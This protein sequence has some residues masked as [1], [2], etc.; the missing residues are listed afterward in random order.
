MVTLQQLARQSSLP[1]E[2]LIA[3]DGSGPETSKAVEAF[4][5]I[6]HNLNVFHIWHEDIGFDKCGV[7]NLAI[8][9]ARSDY[10]L[11]LDDD[12]PC[13]SHFIAEH[14]KR[15]LFGS[16]TVGS[17]VRLNQGATRAILEER[18]L[19]RFLK[20]SLFKKLRRFD[21]GAKGGRFKFF[22]RAAL[23]G[24]FVGRIL[25]RL[26]FVRGVLRGG[27]S[28][29]WRQDLL[30]VNG[31]NEDLKHGHEDKELGIRLTNLGLSLKQ[32][33]FAASNYHLDHERPYAD[34]ELRRKQ[35]DH[36]RSVRRSGE[37]VCVNG[38]KKR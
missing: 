31:F 14:M 34:S 2:I 15:A 38:I 12:C 16:F 4:Q 35:N 19:N 20:L 28:G 29:A 23:S 7:L 37:S 13:P 8:E 5:A 3:D 11:F 24:R 9:R 1:D 25:D 10:I 18:D 26:Y 36:C 27:N 17:S 32:V 33:R 22:L 30:E 21:Y 6:H